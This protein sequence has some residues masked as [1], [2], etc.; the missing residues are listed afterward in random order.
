MYHECGV[1]KYHECAGILFYIGRVVTLNTFLCFK[2]PYG[3]ISYILFLRNCLPIELCMYKVYACESESPT[4]CH[5]LTSHEGKITK[6]QDK[7]TRRR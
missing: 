3:L 1:S 7:R 4:K 2:W 5:F 6:K